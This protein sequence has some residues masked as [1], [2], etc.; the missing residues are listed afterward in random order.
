[1]EP[2]GFRRA[3]V[4][5]TLLAALALLLVETPAVAA[6]SGTGGVTAG[7][8]PWVANA[9]A[10]V[11]LI[12]AGAAAGPGDPDRR[13]GPRA[14]VRARARLARLLE[15]QR[16]RRLPAPARPLGDPRARRGRAPLPRAAALRPARR[17]GELRLRRAGDLPDLSPD[18]GGGRREVAV[19][20]RRGSTISSAA[21]SASPIPPSSP[22]TSSP[23]AQGTGPEALATAARL[24]A[25][26][27]ALPRDPGAVAGAPQVS[28]R[29]EPGPASSLL[30]VFS[31]SGGTLRS[32]DPDLFFE[33]HPFFALERPELAVVASRTDLSG[34]R[35]VR[36]TRPSRCRRRRPSPGR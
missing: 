12:A 27:E 25:A 17:A 19:R 18:P 9:Q 3:R 13:N 30:L 16:R 4:A 28:V 24:T 8:G 10:R 29:V 22:S 33:S 11:R 23:S 20:C 21:R 14:R 35:S 34:C 5:A 6:A 26:R 32:A 31:L 15:E 2:I 7:S 1:M 36:S